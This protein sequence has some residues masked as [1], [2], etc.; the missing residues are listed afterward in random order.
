VVCE[1]VG[2]GELVNEVDEV[3]WVLVCR[4]WVQLYYV[5]DCV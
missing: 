5:C 4:V 3:V 2:F 1:I